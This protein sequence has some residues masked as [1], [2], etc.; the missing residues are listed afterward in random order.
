MRK[1]PSPT[2]QPTRDGADSPGPITQV[3]TMPDRMH[4]VRDKAMIDSARRPVA[5]IMG[6]SGRT[7]A[8]NALCCLTPANRFRLFFIWII[9]Q[10]WFDNISLVVI[11]ANSVVLAVQG[12]PDDPNSP[13]PPDI[14]TTLEIT[15]TIA[16]TVEMIVKIV[17]MGFACHRKRRGRRTPEA[18]PP[19]RQAFILIL[20]SLSLSRSL[21][22]TQQAARTSPTI[23]TGSILSSS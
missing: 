4:L 16:F 17:A 13:I 20:F 23:G 10:Q 18:P 12:P 19:V 11:I 6:P 5:S 14:S 22:Y 9:E 3:E 1:T 21:A 8:G 15:F 2:R 7:Y